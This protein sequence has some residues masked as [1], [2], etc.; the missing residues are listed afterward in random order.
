MGDPVTT[1]LI[2]A[3]VASAGVSAYS[4]I[5]AGKASYQAAEFERAQYEEQSK[6]AEVQ[7]LDEEADRKRRLNQVLSSNM[8]AAA[9]MG[10]STEG[11]SFLA[12]QE[13][14]EAEANRD[15]GR[16]RLNAKSDKYRNSLAAQQAKMSGKAAMKSGYTG[17]ATSL[18][19][20]GVQAGQMYQT[21]Q[22]QKAQLKKT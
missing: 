7:A 16:I 5:Q 10:V 9:A 1:T 15:I 11:R 17:A 22:Y 14:S 21:S 13:E 4:S 2:V 3:S 20:G 8:A 19:S 6:V 18:L 12:I